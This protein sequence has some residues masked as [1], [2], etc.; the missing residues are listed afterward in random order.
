MTT[1]EA[2]A[3]VDIDRQLNQVGWQVQNMGAINIY[4][5]P[6]VAVRDFSL[7]SG[8]GTA[9]RMLFVNQKTGKKRKPGRVHPHE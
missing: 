7:K 2:R 9:Y 4:A 1:P 3:R 5:G 8:H 6:R